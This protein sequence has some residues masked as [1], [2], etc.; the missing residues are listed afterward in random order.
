MGTIVK[1][2]GHGAYTVKLSVTSRRIYRGVNASRISRVD[3][4]ENKSKRTRHGAS[5][6]EAMRNPQKKRCLST[7]PDTTENEES[8]TTQRRLMHVGRPG[9]EVVSPEHSTREKSSVPRV[10]NQPR[11]PIQGDSVKVLYR[12]RE[13]RWAKVASTDRDAGTLLVQY[14]G[15]EM[16]LRPFPH[17]AV[18][19]FT[20]A[21]PRLR[22]NANRYDIPHWYIYHLYAR[23]E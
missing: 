16:E 22:L 4:N 5:T 3:L 13:W 6:S 15:K 14:D 7:G 10:Q 11:W 2:E 8:S 18:M 1:Y 17:F 9:K 23:T 20:R 12:G 19:S 21:D